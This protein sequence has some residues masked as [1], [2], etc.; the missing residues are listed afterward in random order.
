MRTKKRS[1]NTK[2]ILWAFLILALA[3]VVSWLRFND[4]FLRFF[5]IGQSLL[6]GFEIIAYTILSLSLIKLLNSCFSVQ[7]KHFRIGFIISVVIGII[8]TVASSIYQSNILINLNLPFVIFG[9]FFG[10]ILA[11]SQSYGW[12]EDNAPPSPDIEKEVKQ[13]HQPFMVKVPL[14]SQQKR[15]LDILLAIISLII[16]APVWLLI[17]FLIWWEDPG[18]VLFVK[19]AVGL[20]G[21]NFKQLKFRSMIL[22]AEKETGPISGYENDDRVLMFGRF[23]RKTALDEL[24]Q[25]INIILGDMSYVGPRPQRT[26][27]VRVYLQRLPQYALRHQVRPGLSGLAQVVDSYDI[28]PEEK[29]AWDLEYIKRAN[30]IFDFKLAI[31]AFILVFFLRWQSQDKPEKIIRRWLKLEK[32]SL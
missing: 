31:A 29:L 4:H 1:L 14:K 3:Y 18:P 25:L 10:A 7:K 27:L 15:I 5:R 23:L 9:S 8:L 19:N 2:S 30:L 6:I 22:D 12:W 11:T 16:S 26:V 32:P 20:G 28:S 13:R 21:I 17:S 24:P